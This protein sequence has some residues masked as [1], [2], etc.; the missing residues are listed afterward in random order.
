MPTGLTPLASPLG[1]TRAAPPVF[2]VHAHLFNATDV[3]VKG[4][5]AK[6][7]AHSEEWPLNKIYTALAPFLERVGG[8]AP[9]CGEEMELLLK[10]LERSKGMAKQTFDQ[11]LRD[12]IQGEVKSHIETIT[13]VLRSQLPDSEFGR[14][15]DEFDAVSQKRLKN[16]N[17]DF[18]RNALGTPLSQDSLRIKSM[19][20]KAANPIAFK[21]AK[22]NSE[23]EVSD[24]R[25]EGALAIVYY[26][27]SPRFHNLYAYQN[28]YS[29]NESAL[30][31]DA[32]FSAL[33]DFNYWLGCE[34]TPSILH[35]QVL[36]HEQLSVLSSGYVLPLVPYNP[37]TDI[38]SQDKSINL[39]RW[40][41]EERG[42]V[43]VKLYPPMGFL[44]IGNSSRSMKELSS[45]GLSRQDAV[46]LDRKLHDLYKWCEGNGV[47]V[48]A[49]TAHSRGQDSVRDGMSSPEAW[50]QVMKCYANLHISA[51]HFGGDFHDG[52]ADWPAQFVSNM[53]QEGG[54]N[55]NVDVGY[56]DELLD[57]SSSGA[58]RMTTLLKTNPAALDHVMYGSDWHMIAQIENWAGYSE[59]MRRYLSCLNLQDLHA[60]ERRFFFKNAARFFG[61]YK[62]QPNRNRLDRFL[63]K[64]KV[65]T[66]RWLEAIDRELT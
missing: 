19:L 35:D 32:C 65:V 31:I 17:A 58:D 59:G 21:K 51:A 28:A 57:C 15:L 56:L 33:V 55:L 20:E 16:K 3:P 5:I 48:M 37:L 25:V 36:L 10:L 53:L 64:W 23:R 44:P 52:R 42:C 27:L 50:R 66:P 43:G 14:T 41:I 4:Y 40:A 39:V 34:D 54:A 61:L 11:S 7:V 47:P 6:A 22:G 63:G 2:D 46:N 24:Y 30:S 38:R 45:I 1:L 49:H 8:T 29:T 26:M 62:E 13:N 9:S 12:Y 60:A 18:E